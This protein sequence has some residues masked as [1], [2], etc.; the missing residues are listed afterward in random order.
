LRDSTDP[1][2]CQ[3]AWAA[4]SVAL[5]NLRPQRARAA[6]QQALALARTLHGQGAD[7]EGTLLF[8][9][10]CEAADV[11]S[12]AADADVAEPLLSEAQ[13][14]ARPHWPPVRMRAL[15]RVQAS[16]AAARGRVD[17]ALRLYRRLLE[18]SRAAGDPS[19]MTQ[20][21]LIDVLLAAGQP[22]AA[23]DAG[24]S[25][26]ARLAG[27]RDEGHLAYARINLVAALL[28]LQRCD[29][30]RAQLRHAWPTA[31]RVERQA[32]CADYL[33]LLAALE[34]R[35]EAA[36]QLTGAADR[37]YEDTQDARQTNEAAARAQ[38]WAMAESTLGAVEARRLHAMGRGLDDDGVAA[39]AFGT[40][41]ERQQD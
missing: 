2:A 12:D 9:A 25:L 17:E 28:A 38:A 35:P 32:W 20:A 21:N 7:A 26:V 13:E 11:V 37:R 3:Q 5:G 41:A 34:N 19:L 18:L 40:A 16:I 8:D 4:I 31:V 6:A 15:V 23:A 10:L 22:E 1:V 33:A 39:L 24:R 14:I 30:A 27:A 29:E 36:A